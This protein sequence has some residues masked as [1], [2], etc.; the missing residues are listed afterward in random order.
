MFYAFL[1]INFYC[2]QVLQ[3]YRLILQLSFEI[4]ICVC[5]ETVMTMSMPYAR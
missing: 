4:D 5:I 3:F 1:I 2:F